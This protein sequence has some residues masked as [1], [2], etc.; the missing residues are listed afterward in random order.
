M[1]REVRGQGVDMFLAAGDQSD[2]EAL[3]AEL[4]SGG[5]AEAAAGPD[6][7]DGRHNLSFL[8]GCWV[9]RFL[10]AY[11]V[12]RVTPIPP[13]GRVPLVCFKGLRYSMSP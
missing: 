13:S 8:D 4:A 1:S 11:P 7:G 5:Y 10:V 9:V 2:V 12:I 6:D 3:G